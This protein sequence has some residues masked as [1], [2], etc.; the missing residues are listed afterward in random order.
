MDT[1]WLDKVVEYEKPIPHIK[2]L[3]LMKIMPEELKADWNRFI[4]G[5]TGLLCDDGDFG[6]YCWDFDRFSD[7]VRKN[8]ENLQDSAAEWD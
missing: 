7:R 4:T 3:E 5:Q 2:S 1:K 6:I 8:A